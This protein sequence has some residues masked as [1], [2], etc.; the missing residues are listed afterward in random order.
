[1]PQIVYEK[2]ASTWK[3][4]TA[5]A[6]TSSQQQMSPN[7]WP[8]NAQMTIVFMIFI[9]RYAADTSWGTWKSLWKTVAV[10]GQTCLHPPNLTP[11]KCHQILTQNI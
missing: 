7:V 9:L 10:A 3:T 2:F 1:M 5:G 8:K 11:T 6:Q 4:V